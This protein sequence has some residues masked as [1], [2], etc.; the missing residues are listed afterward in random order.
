MTEPILPCPKCGT[1]IKLTE[2]LAAP[3]IDAER[4]KIEAGFDERTKALQQ[5]ESAISAERAKIAKENAE[6]EKTKEALET[7]IATKVAA[8]REAI[9]K[10]AQEKATA[11]AAAELNEIK[12]ELDEK[13]RKLEEAQRAELQV[14]KQREALEQEK[15]EFD[16]KLTRTLDEERSKIRDS[17]RDEEARRANDLAAAELKAVREALADK[18][19]KLAQAQQAE[20][21]IRKQR[22]ALEDEKTRV[23]PEDDPRP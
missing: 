9:T 14:R 1:Q 8:E 3:I 18:D 15:R 7:T 19:A 21:E 2:T 10:Q 6:L 4:R 17:V 16:L 20:V 11:I 12:S 23:R 13:N 22:Q 5:R